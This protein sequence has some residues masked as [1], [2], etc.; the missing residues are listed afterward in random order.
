L[1]ALAGLNLNELLIARSLLEKLALA[2]ADRPGAALNIAKNAWEQAKH[3]WEA[4]QRQMQLFAAT[5]SDPQAV[6]EE[7]RGH[8]QELQFLERDLQALASSLAFDP[9]SPAAASQLTEQL[10]LGPF[11]QI[12]EQHPTDIDSL[13]ELFGPNATS[14]QALLEQAAQWE[15]LQLER[16]LESSQLQQLQG[17]KNDGEDETSR[18][19]QAIAQLTR[20]AGSLASWKGE[21]LAVRY[22]EFQELQAD[23]TAVDSRLGRAEQQLQ[24]LRNKQ[25][26]LERSW[27]RLVQQAGESWAVAENLANLKRRLQS[28]R[29]LQ[30]ATETSRI[31]LQQLLTAYQAASLPELERQELDLENSIAAGQLRWQ[32]L[33]DQHPGLPTIQEAAHPERQEELYAA[34]GERVENLQ[35]SADQLQ[36]EVEQ[37]LRRQAAL[38]GQSPCNVAAAADSLR[39]LQAER[40]RLQREVAALALAF[41]ELKQAKLDYEHTYRQRL[42]KQA[43]GYF[44]RIT[45]SL[46]RGVELDS[47]FRVAV[48]TQ[49]GKAI[50]PSQLSQGARDQLYFSLRL[51]IAD[52]LADEAKLPLI[53]DDPFVNS[54]Q[55]RLDRVRLA[56]TVAAEERQIWLLTHQEQLADWGEPVQMEAK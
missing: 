36:R 3:R 10:A 15:S 56:L 24:E 16:Q 33:I 49:D 54:D 9:E 37:L 1:G 42:A 38:E 31:S 29:Q 6:Y 41:R 45:G 21:E 43:S 25:N 19:Q 23:L 28:Y 20:Q 2:Q 12:A 27:S 35:R 52:L 40:D 11:W 22:A 32:Q 50:L 55:E 8:R 13:F 44:D 34:S 47:E 30:Q 4:W 5:F 48:L 26:R 51:A 17:G 39:E 7:W 14:W 18:L 53:L 46:G